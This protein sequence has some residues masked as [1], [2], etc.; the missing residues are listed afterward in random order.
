MK[1]SLLFLVFVSVFVNAFPQGEKADCESAAPIDYDGNRYATVQI[2][3]QCWMKEN[4]RAT[5]YMDGTLLEFGAPI[6]LSAEY[7]YPNGFKN[8][9]AKYGLLYKGSV[10]F[11][12]AGICPK[13]WHVPTDEE[14]TQLTDYVGSQSQYLC[15]GNA[16]YIAKA[17]SC[18]SGWTEA[19]DG[20]S[21]GHNSVK[22]NATGFSAMPAGYCSDTDYL[23][24]GQGTAFWTS[25]K[26][27][28]YEIYY[29]F[30]VNPQPFVN[31]DYKTFARGFSIRCIRD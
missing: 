18:T 12:P 10:V 1:K 3:E 9:V 28:T 15:A 21:A 5:H 16:D 26:K 30:I 7:F 14:W 17:L 8:H 31:R 6:S 4:L 11:N 20:C 29:R 27:S 13:G 23:S 22:N 25:T 19:T 24:F 2:G